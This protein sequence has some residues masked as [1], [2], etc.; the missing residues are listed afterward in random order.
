MLES[1]VRYSTALLTP[2]IAC[3][4][5]YIAW[6]QWRTNHQR[7]KFERYDRRLRIYE[8]VRRI[9]SII[10]RDADISTDELLKF[11]IAVSEADFLFDPEIPLYL[12]E[13]YKHGLNFW[14]HNQKYRDRGS[15][16]EDYDHETVVAKKKNELDWFM[17]QFELSKTKFRKYLNV[18]K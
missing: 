15:G 16:P 17:K 8:E 5:T 13:I 6:Q 14:E 7:F 1:M 9:L 10:M 2:A 4:T 11:R 18:S 12:E 3:I